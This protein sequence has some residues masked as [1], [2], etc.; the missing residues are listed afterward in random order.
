MGARGGAVGQGCWHAPVGRTWRGEPVA[1]PTSWSSG[2]GLAFLP[3][4]CWMWFPSST[5]SVQPAD[6]NHLLPAPAVVPVSHESQVGAEH[7]WGGG[8]NPL[9]KALPEQG[10]GMP[11]LSACSRSS[12]A[13][14]L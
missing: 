14:Y 11:L 7:G 10:L 6:P 1:L 12:L 8:Q 4:A 5:A 2:G 9:P 13:A 3:R